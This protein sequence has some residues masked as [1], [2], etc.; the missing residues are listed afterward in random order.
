MPSHLRFIQPLLLALAACIIAGPAHADK[1]EEKPATAPAEG[2]PL[3]NGK[4][5]TNWK[6]ADFGGAGEP[7]VRDGLLVLPVGERL[8]GVTW[9]GDELPKANYEITLEAQRLDGT[10][11]FCGLTFPFGESHATLVV[12]GWGGP[13]VGISSIDGNDAAHNETTQRMRFDNK[14]WYRIRLRVQPDRIMAWIDDKQLIDV[15]TKGKKVG[16]REDIAEGKP[17][18]LASFQSTAALRDIKL[19]RVED[20]K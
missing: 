13:V 12:G 5:L 17:L 20:E 2:K 7:E 15:N 6:S 3:F 10:D 14:K 9:T 16:I 4:D 11:F 18:G 19:R 8:T 1:K